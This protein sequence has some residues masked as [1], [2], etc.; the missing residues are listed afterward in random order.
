MRAA[1]LLLPLL[2]SA[3]EASKEKDVE[4]LAVVLTVIHTAVGCG[5]V[6]WVSHQRGE[7]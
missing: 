5:S 3:K 4:G 6:M 2:P 1:L 7:I